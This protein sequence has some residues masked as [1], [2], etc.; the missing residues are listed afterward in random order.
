[1]VHMRAIETRSDWTTAEGTQYYQ[2]ATLSGQVSGILSGSATI[3]RYRDTNHDRDIFSF[4]PGDLVEHL[5]YV[6]D[7]KGNEVGSRTGVQVFLQPITVA[8]Q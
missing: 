8:L 1:M 4:P 2:I 3:H 6:G 5:E 7:T